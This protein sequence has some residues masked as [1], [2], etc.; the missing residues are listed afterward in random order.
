VIGNSAVRYGTVAMTLHW[1]IAVAIIGM[2]IVGKYMHELPDSDANKFALYQLHKSFGITILALTVVRIAWRLM[3]P[4]PPLP[5]S[6]PMWE[7]WAA[8]LSHFALYAFMLGLPLTGWLRVS[9]DLLQIPTLWFGLFEVPHLP[10]G[11]NDDI[12]HV[13]H[14][15]HELLGNALILLLIAHVGAALKHHFWDRDNVLKLMLPFTRVE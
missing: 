13:A 12:S 15:T 9:T 3:H 2:L 14:D 6:M 1:L 11:P 10:V 5:A 8:H 7:R 4:A